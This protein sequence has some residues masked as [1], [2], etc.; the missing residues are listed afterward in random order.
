MQLTVGKFYK[1]RDGRKVE[2]IYSGANIDYNLSRSV[3]KHNI[4]G[5]LEDEYCGRKRRC[6]V[7]FTDGGKYGVLDSDSCMDL[8]SEWR[9]PVEV[10]GWVNIYPTGPGHQFFRNKEDADEG[11]SIG[12]IACVYVS[13]T[14]GTEETK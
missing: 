1:T 2:V 3:T 5:I 6:T 9:D 8:V 4:I 11:R 12:R 14:E 10:K 13:G 7:S